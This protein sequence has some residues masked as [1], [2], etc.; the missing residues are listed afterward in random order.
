MQPPPLDNNKGTQ[1]N[2]NNLTSCLSNCF[3]FC[4]LPLDPYPCEHISHG[5]NFIY[6]CNYIYIYSAFMVNVIL[7]IFLVA[8]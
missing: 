2:E 4:P 6:R 7:G 1:E 5:C 3:H 8:I